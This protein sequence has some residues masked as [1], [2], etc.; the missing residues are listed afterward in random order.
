MLFKAHG[1]RGADSRGHPPRLGTLQ[2]RWG[3][4]GCSCRAETDAGEKQHKLLMSVGARRSQIA[5]D[6]ARGWKSELWSR[7]TIL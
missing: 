4:V 7:F 2:S 1:R 3:A 5:N 6:E